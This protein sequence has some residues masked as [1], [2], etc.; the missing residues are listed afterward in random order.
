MAMKRL[1][2]RSLLDNLTSAFT[3]LLLLPFLALCLL[4]PAAMLERNTSGALV[5]VL[6]TGDG[7]VEMTLDL[8]TGTDAPQT[9]KRCDWAAA[10]PTALDVAPFTLPVAAATFD[11]AAPT[12]ANPAWY[13]AHDPRNLWARG[14]PT[15][16]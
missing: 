11:R 9:N 2:S 4:S 13:P 15:L 10:H 6:C 14:P 7:P 3:A 1:R 16:V 8:G 12:L 5:L